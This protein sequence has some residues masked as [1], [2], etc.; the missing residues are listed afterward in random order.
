MNKRAEERLRI[1]LSLRFTQRV[2]RL[3]REFASA[4]GSPPVDNPQYLEALHNEIARYDQETK[5]LTG[6]AG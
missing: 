1:Q 3:M 5:L 6:G 2:K 4:D